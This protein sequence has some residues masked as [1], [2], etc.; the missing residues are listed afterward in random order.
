M[1]SFINSVMKNIREYKTQII[2][3]MIF[4]FLCGRFYYL[5]GFIGHLKPTA[6]APLIFIKDIL[7]ILVC[8]SY[9]GISKSQLKPEKKHLIAFALW[10]TSLSA[11]ILVHFFSKSFNDWGQHYI[12]NV[13]LVFLAAP[14]LYAWAQN[15][16]NYLLEVFFY[17]GLMNALASI[18]QCLFLEDTLLG[19]QR[20]LGLVGDPIS[21]TLVMFI[22]FVATIFKQFPIWLAALLYILSGYVINISGS[23]SATASAVTGL[24]ILFYFFYSEK[25]TKKIMIPIAFLLVGIFIPMKNDYNSVKHKAWVFV[26]GKAVGY[27]GT[28]YHP[29]TLSSEKNLYESMNN[30]RSISMAA[31]SDALNLDSASPATDTEG[32][33]INRFLKLAFGDYLNPV[34]SRYDSTPAVLIVNWGVVVLVLFYLTILIVLAKFLFYFIRNKPKL[35]SEQMFA[36][37][38]V[39]IITTCGFANSIWYRSPINFILLLSLMILMNANQTNLTKA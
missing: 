29:A 7:L 15:K 22:F 17:A 14:A 18:A 26:W 8:V 24:A 37:F 21:L 3:L 5:F 10:L 30:G 25:Q 4:F 13:F 19:G 9:F 35:S 34:Y 2:S 38:C 16:K 39:V 6:P 33:K 31:T 12:R 36:F 32:K 20:P 23:F 1:S 28:E 27:V 11:V